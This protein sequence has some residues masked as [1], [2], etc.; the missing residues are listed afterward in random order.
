MEDFKQIFLGA[1][2]A[3][4]FSILFTFP[5]ILHINSYFIG[6]GGDNYE[7]AGYQGLVVK[8]ISEGKL[9]FS[10]TDFWR[11]PVGFEF[12]RGFDSFLSVS[13]GAVFHSVLNFPTSY[14]LTVLTLMSLNGF[15]SFLFFRKLTKSF[16]LAFLGMAI[17][18][19]S[20]YT[21]AKASSHLNLLFIGGFPLLS[22]SILNF[23]ERKEVLRR[24]IVLFF[25]SL[26]LILL[27][28][29]QYAV[30]AAISI[31][32]TLITTFIFYP[33]VLISLKNKLS[34][35]KTTIVLSLIIFSSF[36][37]FLFAPHIL[38]ALNGSIVISGREDILAKFT[39]SILDF[40]LPN[41]Y[42]SPLI[43]FFSNSSLPSIEKVVF[44]GWAEISILAML[45]FSKIPFRGKLFLTSLI[46][47]PFLL[48]LGYGEANN[49]PLLP[50]RFI[51][52]IFP[53]K[54][55]AEPGRYFII[56]YFFIAIAILISLDSIRSSRIRKILIAAAI[57]LVILERIPG[58]FYRAEAIKNEPYIKIVSQQ[59]TSG[60]LDM[61]ISFY[62]SKYDVLSFYYQKPIVNG[63]FHWSADGDTERSF[64]EREELL[65]RYSCNEDDPVNSGIDETEK[66]KDFKMLQM[67]KDEN[68]RTIV[69]HKDDKFY[70][71][72]CDN[73]RIRLSSLIPVEY[74]LEP[75]SSD[76]QRQLKLESDGLANYSVYVP[77]SGKLYIDGVYFASIN[78][79]EL[80]IERAGMTNGGF[81]Y[82]W[83][84]TAHNAVEMSP[85]NSIEIQVRGG[86]TIFFKS[87]KN[88]GHSW[89]SIWYRYIP[90]TSDIKP[91]KPAIQRVF[92]DKNTAVYKIN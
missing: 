81:E 1:I 17:Y 86:E 9:P 14:N 57:I 43:R 13:L 79:T 23:I 48:A 24:D 68:I 28:S 7:Y 71:S 38:G 50:Y 61:P 58:S 46:L 90:E 32:I 26:T 4:L 35:R 65:S 39:P 87:Q 66:H 27:G 18:G 49:F 74:S 47:V 77:Y 69:I 63:Y 52:S 85:K 55:I 41:T 19:F 5:S 22:L 44:I 72:V 34:V 60:V 8:N 51:S 15:L 36:V 21:L 80:N 37:L 42:L 11:Y 29:A 82:T 33:E 25:F 12:P 83:T 78:K 16:W 20:F 6:D 64:I 91:Y 70:H 2:L 53:F 75:N 73:V 54:L 40:V 45:I 30:L 10:S 92:E 89:F 84:E 62:Y 56:F 59:D 3:I 76:R 31:I 88:A 67:L